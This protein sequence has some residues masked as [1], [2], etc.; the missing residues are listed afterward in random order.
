MHDLVAT[1]RRRHPFVKFGAYL[2]ATFG[3]LGVSLPAQAEDKPV[4]ET[5]W[6]DVCCDL[7]ASQRYA[8]KRHATH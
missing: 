3:A 1:R 4:A 5:F 6:H 8:T 7:L 2:M